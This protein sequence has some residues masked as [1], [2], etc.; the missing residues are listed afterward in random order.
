MLKHEFMTSNRLEKNVINHYNLFFLILYSWL[1]LK[2]ASVLIKF[3]K[4]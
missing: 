2:N 4:K 1:Q 3:A